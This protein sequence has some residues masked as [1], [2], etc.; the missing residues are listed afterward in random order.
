MF[1]AQAG[2]GIMLDLKPDPY[3]KRTDQQ[4]AIKK[5]R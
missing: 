5:L 3:P 1:T 2:T 4:A